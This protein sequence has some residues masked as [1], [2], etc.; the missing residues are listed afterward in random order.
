MS[1]LR[2]VH[3]LFALCPLSRAA[4]PEHSSSRIQFRSQ[5][6][7]ASG[8]PRALSATWRIC[9]RKAASLRQSARSRAELDTP[10]SLRAVASPNWSLSSASISAP[11]RVLR[12]SSAPT[13][14]VIRSGVPPS[15]SLPIWS[16]RWR[17]AV[18][19]WCANV[20]ANASI[21]DSKR[22]CKPITSRTA[23]AR[24]RLGESLK[25]SSRSDLYSSS[26]RDS[27]NSGA[28]SGSPSISTLTTRRTG[29]PPCMRR[30]SSLRRRTMTS[31]K[32]PLRTFTPRVNRWGSSS[33]SSAE[34]LWECPL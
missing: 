6:S 27:T 30:M 7:L 11:V 23:K 20:N 18:F 9:S 12:S 17:S 16:R 2:S 22:C 15:P 24:A 5:R 10:R 3:G 13:V 28:S 21:E 33:S 8:T 34:K 14:P 26:S 32:A 29:N 19:M 25:R 1:T 4:I 31:F